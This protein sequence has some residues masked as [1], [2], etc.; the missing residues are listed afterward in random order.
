MSPFGRHALG[1]QAIRDVQYSF[2]VNQPY[3]LLTGVSGSLAQHVV[4][5]MDVVGRIGVRSSNYRQSIASGRRRA[6]TG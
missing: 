5:P 1:L 6:D 4:G 2:D 3:Y